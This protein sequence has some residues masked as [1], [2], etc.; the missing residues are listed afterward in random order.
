MINVPIV[1]GLIALSFVLTA[2]VSAGFVLLAIY[3]L[4]VNAI[5]HTAHAVLFRTYN[6]GLGTALVLFFPLATY[7]LLTPSVEDGVAWWMHALAAGIAIVAHAGVGLRARQNLARH[8]RV[9]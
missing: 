9:A 7:G 2:T 8:A 6:P 3:L 4:L 5:A 1:W